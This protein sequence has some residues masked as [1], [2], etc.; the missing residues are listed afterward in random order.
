L[1]G[2]N[3]GRIPIK[4]LSHLE[5][6]SRL[7]ILTPEIFGDFGNRIDSNT[8]EAVSVNEILNPRLEFTSDPRVILIK[9]WKS[10]K[11]AVFN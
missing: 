5:N 10:S 8:V 1:I 3:I 6:A 11:T 7:T 4:A 2:T 9:V